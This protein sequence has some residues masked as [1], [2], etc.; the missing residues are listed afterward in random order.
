MDLYIIQPW[1]EPINDHLM[2][3]LLP[4]DA[5]RRALARAANLVVP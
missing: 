3:L 4:I 2:E 1:S 5:F